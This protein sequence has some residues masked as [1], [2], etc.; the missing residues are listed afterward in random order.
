MA[1]GVNAT[2]KLLEVAAK[3]LSQGY[4]IEVIEAHHSKK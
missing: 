2:F 1:V 4:D 3:I